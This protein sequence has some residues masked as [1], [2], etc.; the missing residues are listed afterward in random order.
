MNRC[1]YVLASNAST[2]ISAPNS[3]PTSLI[4]GM[5]DLFIDQEKERQKLKMQ[6]STNEALVYF[7]YF[8]FYLNFIF[9]H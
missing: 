6:V 8:E 2:R 9:D 7:L 5:R 1:T 4:G 3:P